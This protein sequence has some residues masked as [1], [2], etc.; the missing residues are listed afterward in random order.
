MTHY[1]TNI[2][3]IVF[4]LAVLL[5]LLV[6]FRSVR[7][8][9][10]GKFISFDQDISKR[11]LQIISAL[12]SISIVICLAYWLIIGT[13]IFSVFL[14]FLNDLLGT[15]QGITQNV[16]SDLISYVNPKA[17]F[18]G[19]GLISFVFVFTAFIL[20][21]FL[22]KR[23]RETR[24]ADLLIVCWAFCSTIIY[25]I[26]RE[27]LP[28]KYLPTQR[29]WVYSLPLVLVMV[30]SIVLRWKGLGR[31]A[32]V[33]I[34]ILFAIFNVYTL[35]IVPSNPVSHASLSDNFNGGHIHAAGIWS[36]P[37]DGTVLA[38]FSY[39]HVI[40]YWDS[41]ARVVGL[42]FYFADNMKD[43]KTYITWLYLDQTP[44]FKVG[45]YEIHALLTPSQINAIKNAQWLEKVYS[46][47]QWDIYYNTSHPPIR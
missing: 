36:S 42:N 39:D 20:W 24:R 3:L 34:I 2:F 11:E 22:V 41:A 18:T 31:I 5:S 40:E 44:K 33:F 17:L 25:I 7:Q 4:F 9:K 14:S 28:E 38:P 13:S 47:G 12:L 16:P 45:T 43:L 6:R 29:I 26:C 19:I 35:V 8:S 27:T 37:K 10:L 23:F 30:S 1:T 15:V 21:E 32:G 46:N